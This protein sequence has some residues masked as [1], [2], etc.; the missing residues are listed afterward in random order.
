[1]GI[2]GSLSAEAYSA[3]AQE[4][5]D[6]LTPIAK[7]DMEAQEKAQAEKV[8]FDN[9]VRDL[10]TAIENGNVSVIES[11]LAHY[12]DHHLAL[13]ERQRLQMELG[14]SNQQCCPTH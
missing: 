7:A 4:S 2:D 8:I 13:A 5:I 14:K 3:K 12:P 10:R 6:K 9:H 1:M 11:T